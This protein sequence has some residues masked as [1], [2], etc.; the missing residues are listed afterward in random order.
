MESIIFVSIG[1]LLFL[2]FLFSISIIHIRTIR[3]AINLKWY[4]LVEKLQYRQDLIPNLIETLRGNVP[5]D[6]IKKHGKLINDT[7][8]IR[9]RAARNSN[10]GA[11]KVVVEHDLSRHITQI[12]NLGAK[13]NNFGRS[14]NYLELKKDFSDLRKKIE[15]RT[16]DYNEIVRKHNKEIQYTY[17]LLPSKLMRYGKKKIF[18]FE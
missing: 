15:K 17:N 7:I 16:N 4:N 6:E 11:S 13:Y 5:E 18:E 14:T 10:A 8:N 1:V 2:V 3:D 9:A 12:F